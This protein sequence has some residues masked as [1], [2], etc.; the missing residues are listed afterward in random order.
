METAIREETTATD[1]EFSLVRG[2]PFYRIQQSARVIRTGE[3]N[4]A[5]RV[6][7]A[8]AVTWLPLIFL[9]ILFHF[10]G[11]ISLLQDYRVYSRLL[12]AV[13]VLL[14]GQ[15]L[16]ESSFRLVMQHIL[17]AHL[18]TEV[19][20]ARLN[21]TKTWLLR[22][23]DSLLPEVAI[24]LLVVTHTLTTYKQL[25]DATPWLAYG[26]APDL[27]L[28]PAGWYAVLVSATVFQFL[29]G[30]GLW[31]WLL[32]T[33]FAFRLSRL[34]LRLFPT[35]PDGH[36]GLG[37]LALTAEAF[38]P[39][40]FATATV[41][42]A[43]WR[44]ELLNHQSNPMALR[45]P[46]VVLLVIIAFVAL[47]PLAFFVRRLATLRRQGMEE[48][49]VLGQIHSAEFHQKWISHRAGHEEEF[50]TASEIGALSGYSRSYNKLEHLNPF[51]ADKIDF[52]VLAIS[53]A[54]PMLPVILT[55]F[56]LAVI[57]KSLLK[58]LR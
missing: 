57:V 10:E 21:R 16:M 32:W 43:T 24:L 40:S 54:V 20:L 17:E 9:T 15:P 7:L 29:L 19:D 31:K 1:P 49:G 18:L 6:T 45:L 30:L 38:T 26:V 53:V 13:P 50:L 36:G 48:Y 5:R 25:V 42:G 33:M 44:H 34:N 3:W 46:A 8:I 12:V 23:R 51:P 52:V 4:S 58:A 41:I 27:R 22:L 39:I 55:M 56:P 28:T 37:F 14:L 35:H 2:G 11:L 47:G